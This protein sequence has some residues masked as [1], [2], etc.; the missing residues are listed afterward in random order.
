MA[1][2]LVTVSVEWQVHRMADPLK[3]Y[4]RNVG[5][6]RHLLISGD[7]ISGTLRRRGPSAG[8]GM[9]PLALGRHVV[10]QRWGPSGHKVMAYPIASTFS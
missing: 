8:I 6:C 10:Y 7:P 9:C 1:L 3:G 5:I 4:S 2:G